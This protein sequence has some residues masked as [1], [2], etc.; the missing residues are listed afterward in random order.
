VA[1][2][3]KGG[4]RRKKDQ[5]MAADLAKRGIYHGKRNAPVTQGINYPH[6][7][8]VGSAAYRRARYQ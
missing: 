3:A 1:A 2:N 6:L 4:A 7:G 5:E 8:D